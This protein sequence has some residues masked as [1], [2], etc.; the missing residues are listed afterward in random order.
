MTYPNGVGVAQW[1]CNGLQRNDPGF[2]SRWGRCRNWASSPSQGTVNG[3]GATSLND[4]VVDGTLNTTNQPTK[5]YPMLIQDNYRKRN[6][7]E[8]HPP[9]ERSHAGIW[10]LTRRMLLRFRW[11]LHGFI[12]DI[13]SIIG[14]YDLSAFISNFIE[15]GY[16]PPKMIWKRLVQ[17]NVDNVF[18]SH[19]KSRTHANPAM[20]RFTSIHPDCL[21]PLRLWTA[22]KVFPRSREQLSSLA[23][24][25]TI[26]PTEVV[27][28]LCKKGA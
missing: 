26:I 7:M 22:T 20:N 24:L 16:F 14:K 19:F 5:P 11:L 13:F 2:D 21:K 10:D 1:L 25:C 28:S 9:M 27:C 6:C 12:A 8:N 4:L 15:T 23:L 3:G 18:K 17:R